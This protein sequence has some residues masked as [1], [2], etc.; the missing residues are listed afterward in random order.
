[1]IVHTDLTIQ[2]S[3]AVVGTAPT[4]AAITVN[5]KLNGTLLFTLTIPA[6]ATKSNTFTGPRAIQQGDL[7]SVDIT[8]VGST[9]PGADLTVMVR[10]V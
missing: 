9:D 10:V 5:V 4:G 1:M 2:D 3:Y 6:G 8:A 7:L